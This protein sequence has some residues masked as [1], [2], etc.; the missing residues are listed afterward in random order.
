MFIE[1]IKFGK[2]SLVGIVTGSIA[3]LASITPASG[4]VGPIG[5][6]IIGL[7]SGYLCYFAVG[8]VKNALKSDDSRDVFAVHGVGGTLGVLLLPFLI[9]S[10][11]GGV[12][13]S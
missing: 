7:V 10:N 1:W 6:G 2:P 3:G 5:A 4:F 13:L 9:G 8:V 12:G 11:L